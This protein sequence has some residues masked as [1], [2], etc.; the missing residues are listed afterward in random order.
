MGL[1]AAL[2]FLAVVA[3]AASALAQDSGFD[4][5]YNLEYDEAL[6]D[7]STYAQKNPADAQAWNHVAQTI[8]FRQ[9]FRAGSLESDLIRADSFLRRPKLA[10]SAP[11]DNQLSQA[12]NKAIDISQAQL[13]R[14]GNDIPALYALGVSYGIRANY[15]FLVKK[16]WFDALSDTA[17][18]RKTHTRVTQLDPKMI[19]A[20]LILGIHE[21]VVGSL[22]WGMKM[23]GSVAGFSGDKEHGIQ[24]LKVVASQ[25]SSNR[26][27]AAAVLTAIYRREKRPRESVPLL[28]ELIQKFPRAYL[29][30]LE[31][32]EA[33]GDLNDRNSALAK[34]DEAEKLKRSGA[35]GFSRLPDAKIRYTRGTLLFNFGDLDRA[36][37]DM[38]SAAAGSNELD[39]NTAGTAWLRLGQIYDLKGQRTQAVESY[40]EA[41]RRAPESDAASEAKGYI[42]SRYKKPA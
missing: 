28:E 10:L 9:M 31:L 19:D 15:D 17:S 1:G 5:F 2:R 35:P 25:G 32:A 24:T 13:K 22:P 34:V 4:H 39:T 40:R 14:N 21:Y 27:D 6:A 26:Y 11:D 42:G 23:L 41:V 3:I 7:F 18:A 16:A 33:Y 36:L 37:E 20:Q 38:K 30:R 12:V 8:L 29:L